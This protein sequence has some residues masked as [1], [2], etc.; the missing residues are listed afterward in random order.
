MSET[1]KTPYIEATAYLQVVD[2]EPGPH[3]RKHMAA[4]PYGGLGKVV[5]S[6]QEKPLRPQAG[7]VVVKITLRIPKS[8]FL[9]LE[10][11]AVITIP[12]HLISSPVVEVEATD[13]KG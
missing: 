4:R 10:P 7:A 9:P 8:A 3:G 12:N 5:A 6:T 2:T 11:E 1:S 13:P